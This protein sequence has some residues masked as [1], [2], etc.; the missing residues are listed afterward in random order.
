MAMPIILTGSEYDG[1]EEP[2]EYFDHA[3]S[4]T[5]IYNKLKEKGY[6]IRFYSTPGSIRNVPLGV[7]NNIV[8]APDIYFIGDKLKYLQKIY[9]LTALYCSPQI[10]KHHFMVNTEEIEAL[11]DIT[12][13]MES[14]FHFSGTSILNTTPMPPGNKV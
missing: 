13:L 4:D 7:A 14:I 8:S 2:N 3:W 1:F 9:T 6:D 10:V 12:I 11:L 5:D